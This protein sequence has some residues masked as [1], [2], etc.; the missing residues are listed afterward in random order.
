[1]NAGDVFRIVG[2]ADHSTVQHKTC[3]L[4]SRA[5]SAKDADLNKLVA[6]RRLE[7]YEPLSRAVLERVRIGAI[8]STRIPMK[9]KK[10]LMDQGFFP[11][12]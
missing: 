1:M 5:V 2:K 9:F 6:G 11:P 12:P 4:Y 7:L 8:R 3:I 10:I